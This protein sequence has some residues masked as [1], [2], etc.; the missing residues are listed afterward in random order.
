MSGRE[1]SRPT[2]GKRCSKRPWALDRRA[3]DGSVEGVGCAPYAP[4][5]NPRPRH[6]TAGWRTVSA[7]LLAL[8][9]SVPS[10]VTARADDTVV[11]PDQAL[12]ACITAELAAEHLDTGLTPTNLAKLQQVL[13]TSGVADLTGVENLSG[14]T[15]LQVFPSSVRDISAVAGLSSL[16]VL[17]VPSSQPYDLAP[18]V[19]LPRLVKLAVSIHGGTDVGPIARLGGLQL[20]SLQLRGMSRPP[21]LTVPATVE[22]LSVSGDATM[23]G[24]GRIGGGA[25][26]TRLSLYGP[27]KL[28]SLAGLEGLTAVRDLYAPSLG[29]RDISAVAGMKQLRK[30]ELAHNSVSDLSPLT[31]LVQLQSLDLSE[32]RVTNVRPLAGLTRLKELRLALATVSDV[33]PLATLDKLETLDLTDNQVADLSPLAGLPSLSTLFAG[34][35]RLA[36]LGPSSGLSHLTSA[37]FDGNRLT[38]IEGLR[39]AQLTFIDL[40]RNELSDIGPLAAVSP[41]AGVRLSF[42]HIRNLSPLPASVDLTASDQSLTYPQA[43]VGVPFDL[44]I[45][46]LGG[47]PV[48]PTSSPASRCTDGRITYPA[49]GTYSLRITSAGAGFGLY[50]SQHAGPDRAFTRT[51]TPKLSGRPAVGLA[52]GVTTRD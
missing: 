13:C 14:L 19:G 52:I 51:F 43:T 25:G 11:I 6:G 16:E 35:N 46:G 3:V 20:L 36:N 8:A 38:S 5:V 9:L 23:T 24:L 42:N 41:G 30:L 50:A 31:G 28:S 48:C 17:V 10:S 22:D 33:S 18:L 27:A 29:V 2:G 44:G 49:S 4:A 7:T 32:N 1:T 39:G 26:V 15:R 45:R 37:V 40:S 34:G 21:D 12:R 47:V